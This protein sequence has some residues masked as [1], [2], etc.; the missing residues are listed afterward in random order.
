[1]SRGQRGGSPTVVN[2]SF[3]D[4]TY[5]ITLNNS[6]FFLSNY[7]IG[8]NGNALLVTLFIHI[9]IVSERPL[10]MYNTSTFVT[11]QSQVLE[12]TYS[13]NLHNCDYF[14]LINTFPIIKSGNTVLQMKKLF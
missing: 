2:L 10:E 3:L 4:Q 5:K 14:K 8:I 7:I 9:F 12:K 6:Q 13:F 11:S 1:V